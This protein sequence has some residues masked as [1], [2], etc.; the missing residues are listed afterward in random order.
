MREKERSGD[1]RTYY[2]KEELH[3]RLKLLAVEKDVNV[4]DLVVEGI[5]HVL[6]KYKKKGA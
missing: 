4:S 1:R 6:K 2:V 5:E 3:K